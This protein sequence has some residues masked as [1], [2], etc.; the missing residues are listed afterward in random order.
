M[1]QSDSRYK[2]GRGLRTA[3]RL[4]EGQ[5]FRLDALDLRLASPP[6]ACPPLTPALSR[7]LSLRP[8]WAAQQSP[9][10]PKPGSDVLL[11]LLSEGISL[12]LFTV[13]LVLLGSQLGWKCSHLL[14]PRLCDSFFRPGS[15]CVRQSL[16]PALCWR[17]Y[18]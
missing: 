14:K 4:S 11:L 7:P 8:A 10:Q 3:V 17:R 13:N 5:L 12:L 16:L 6:L 9:G 15:L 2:R 1:L 18:L